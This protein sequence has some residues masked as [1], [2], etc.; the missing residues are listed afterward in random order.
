MKN[1]VI[2]TVE[3]KQVAA[4]AVIG[5]ASSSKRQWSRCSRLRRRVAVAAMAWLCVVASV[6]VGSCFARLHLQSVGCCFTR[7]LFGV[8]PSPI[9]E[10]YV[11]CELWC[12]CM[13]VERKL[14][15]T[16]VE[17]RAYYMAIHNVLLMSL[18]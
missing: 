5:E 12:E 18:L 15:G 4:I 11:W 10:L 3:V 16:Q 17:G 14:K 2:V 1:L 7:L 9:S 8:S 13:L 6:T